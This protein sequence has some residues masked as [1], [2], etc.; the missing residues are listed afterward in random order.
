MMDIISMEKTAVWIYAVIVIGKN[1]FIG[2]QGV[3]SAVHLI[4]TTRIKPRK[5][6][7][8]NQPRQLFR[9][10]SVEG[11]FGHGGPWLIMSRFWINLLS[12][13]IQIV[14]HV[15]VHSA[16]VECKLTHCT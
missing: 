6:N 2:S 16:F 3:T 14:P 10:Y 9:G 11:F 1:H 4:A 8:T 12:T 7:L 15:S 13:L 5:E